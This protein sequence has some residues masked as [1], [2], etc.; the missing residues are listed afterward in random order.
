MVDHYW[1]CWDKSDDVQKVLLDNTITFKINDLP[2]L[3]CKQ[4]PRDNMTFFKQV[5]VKDI[6]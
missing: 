6:L 2:M 1:D 4:N 5:F 3:K